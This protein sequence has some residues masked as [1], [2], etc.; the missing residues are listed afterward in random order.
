[1]KIKV[2]GGTCLSVIVSLIAAASAGAAWEPAKPIDNQGTTGHAA[3]NTGNYAG[4]AD[5]AGGSATAFFEQTVGGTNGLFANRRGAQD[6]AWATPSSA[7]FSG[8]SVFAD[9]PISAAADASGNAFG[10]AVQEVNAV[11][12]VFTA[13]WP[14]GATA[15]SAYS[16]LMSTST[17]QGGVTDPQ[18][19][20]DRSGNGYVVAGVGQGSSSD[21]PIL[22][23]NYSAAT[24]TW[25]KPAPIT[26]Q[27]GATTCSSG[28]IC[29]QEPRMAVSPDGAMVVAYLVTVPGAFPGT[30][31]EELFAA[32]APA[33]AV[34]GA[35]AFAPPQQISQAGDQVPDTPYPSGSSADYPPNYDV[36][37]DGSDLATIVDAESQGGFNNQVF[38]SQWPADAANPE[39]PVAISAPP[40]PTGSEPPATEPRVVSDAAGDVT[41]VWTEASQTSPPPADAL[42]S[43]EVVGGRWTNPESVAG[44]VDSPSNPQGYSVNTPPFSLAEDPGGT[45]WLVWTNGGGL[46]DTIR[47]QG[48]A[49]SSVDT[50]AGVSGAVA[51]TARVAAGLTGQ[52]DTVVVASGSSRNALYAS[53]FAAPAPLPPPAPSATAPQPGPPA[54]GTGPPPAATTSPTQFS[55]QVRPT[56]RISRRRTHASR[57]GIT[58]A[59]VAGERKCAGA[60]SAVAEFNQVVQVYVM[61]Y[62]PAP[63]GLCRFLT[64]NG[65]VTPPRSCRH[66]IE[67]LARGTTRWL[68]RLRVHV[69][70]GTYLIRSDARDGFGRRQRHSAASVQRIKVR[71]RRHRR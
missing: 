40:P 50:I 68:L 53:R 26:D 66:P 64:R 38:A 3:G 54:N 24:G 8:G 71:A 21:E 5:G 2:L 39:H 17:G 11:P 19:G 49:W 28:E 37:I 36:T 10:A 35:G 25:S 4:L 65:K 7:G 16:Q 6:A 43:A 13:S 48:K 52:G 47:Q 46:Q 20:F 69:P 41:A 22:L 42:L 18:V 61:I 59:G 32:R 12:G 67:F 45:A 58:V 51:G 23:S 55:C 15:P 34:A 27:A 57:R 29:G 14:A 63:H 60:T 56:S 30:T 44:T 31:Q 62:H 1:M 70:A 33:G 9:L